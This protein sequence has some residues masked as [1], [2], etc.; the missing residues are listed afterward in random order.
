MFGAGIL[1]S[2]GE[3]PVFWACGVTP[4]AVVM[5]AKPAFC[6]THKPGHM[7]QAI[8]DHVRLGRELRVR[9][10]ADELR[11]RKPALG[12]VLIERAVGQGPL[13]G[14]KMYIR[15]AAQPFAQVP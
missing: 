1:S 4:Q 13:R 7:P 10:V 9:A 5:Q 11:H 15:F 6:A 12:D 14:D 3:I 8:V 2:T